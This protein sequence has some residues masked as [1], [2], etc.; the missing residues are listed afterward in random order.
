MRRRLVRIGI[1]AD[2]HG[3]WPALDAWA[4]RY[5]LDVVVHCGDSGTT[6]TGGVLVWAARGNHDHSHS[7]QGG[8]GRPQF[9]DDYEVREL[10]GLRWLFLG[11]APGTAG[12]APL[13]EALPAL[14]VVVS[15]EAPFNPHLGWTGHPAVRALVE[16]AQPRWCFSGHWH[17]A[18][19]QTIGR[20]EC[21]ALGAT[22]AGWLIVE[23]G[24]GTL[25]LTAL[26]SGRSPAA[27]PDAEGAEAA[28][29]S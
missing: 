25:R 27:Q 6:E 29:R 14:D 9:V 2:S 3:D 4:A 10:A 8:A 18:G 23:A 26:A 11:C 24:D 17:H 20:T 12:V 5:A 16:R 19:R 22:P 15:H 13:P 7:I 28:R 1:A 21:Y